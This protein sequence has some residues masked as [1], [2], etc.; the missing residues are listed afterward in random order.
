[1]AEQL[2]RV[3]F[4]G[5]YAAGSS[6]QE[7]A[8]QLA[9]LGVATASTEPGKPVVLK[10]DLSHDQALRYEAALK[11]TGA[12]CR[13]EPCGGAAPVSRTPADAVL[14]PEPTLAVEEVPGSTNPYPL[15]PPELAPI[16]PI[17]P[18][19]EANPFLDPSNGTLG[20]G[21]SSDPVNAGVGRIEAQRA[22]QTVAPVP[23]S[24]DT[25]TCPKCGL[26]QD[27]TVECVR[28]GVVVAKYEERSADETWNE[29]RLEDTGQLYTGQPA[30]KH[31]EVGEDD[32]FFAPEKKGVE[33][34]ML[35]GIAMMVIA[36][37]WFALGWMAGII[38][39]YPPI[40]FIIGLFGLLK[41][42][43]TGNVVGTHA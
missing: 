1:M 22:V 40:L 25:M 24:S 8:N 33:K 29:A 31:N 15:P 5:E 32:G 11:A 6:P 3:V 7:V 35:G 14:P 20:M 42:L 12:L 16:D 17:P 36:V 37:V 26:E 4:T 2:Y 10:Q 41:G 34:G 43:F 28:C 30:V 27:E 9:F 13:V 23:V 19:P 18:L 21:P 39:Y 38:F